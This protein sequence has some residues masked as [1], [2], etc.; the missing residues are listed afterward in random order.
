MPLNLDFGG[1][2]EGVVVVVRLAAAF[3]GG[4]HE[5]IDFKLQGQVRQRLIRSKAH[6]GQ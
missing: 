3:E 2:V 1:A 6:G 4:E 5:V